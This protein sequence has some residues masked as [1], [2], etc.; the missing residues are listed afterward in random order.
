[1]EV[2]V[3]YLERDKKTGI[4]RYRRVYPVRLRPFISEPGCRPVQLK[5]TLE[6]REITE[7]GAAERFERAAQRYASIVARAEK[8]AS[9][10]YDTLAPSTINILMDAFRSQQLSEDAERRLDPAAKARGEQVTE[11][12]KLA[13]FELPVVRPT[14]KWSQGI[15][16]TIETVLEVYRGLSADGD[17]DGIVWA[18]GDKAEELAEVA[19][20]VLDRSNP[21]FQ[22]LCLRLNETAIA[23]HE[24]ELGRMEGKIIDT[25]PMPTLPMTSTPPPAPLRSFRTIVE[26][27]LANP[28][29]EIGG[30]TRAQVG[31]ALR[32]LGD[33]LG[34]PSPE[35]L[36]KTEVG[37]WLDVISQRPAFVTAAERVMPL[38]DLVAKYEGQDVQR[39]SQGTLEKHC[40]VLSKRWNHAVKEG[41]IPASIPNPFEGRSFGTK[42]RGPKEVDGFTEGELKDIFSLPFFGGGP[43]PRWG[44]GEAAYWLPLLALYTGA[45]PE[46]VAQLVV[47]N[48]YGDHETERPVFDFAGTSAHPEKGQQRLKTQEKGTGPRVFPIPADLIALGFMDY[49]EWLQDHGEEALFPKLRVRNKF[50][51]LYPSFGEPWCNAL[52]DAGILKRRS[53]RKPM[54]EFR[55]TFVTGARVSRIPEPS[56]GY[57][58]GHTGTGDGQPRMTAKYGKLNPHAVWIDEYRPLIDVLELVEPWKPPEAPV[59]N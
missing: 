12:A 14:A 26:D 28:R 21:S 49:V 47:G 6:A 37:R 45:R 23:V 52:Y 10:R 3:P 42:S 15:R 20:L 48:I 30:P 7:P 13:G 31:T 59:A 29:F 1:M 38:G 36:T 34:D 57:I 18:W 56:I 58:I 43:P 32:Y 51:R 4:L 5:V 11:A 8:L 50:N 39:A 41:P 53:G 46:E 55:D 9:G 33:V 25:P 19:G 22:T 40:R 27:M 44:K 35:Q 2:I 16:V 24:A 17:I 54:R